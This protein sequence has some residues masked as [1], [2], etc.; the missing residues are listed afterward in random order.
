VL[1]SPSVTAST[2]RTLLTPLAALNAD[3]AAASDEESNPSHFHRAALS[4][5]SVFE[6]VASA[7]AAV[8]A[9]A[10]AVAACEV[11]GGSVHMRE[12]RGWGGGYSSACARGGT[13][14]QQRR[15]DGTL[16][17]HTLGTNPT[18]VDVDKRKIS[19]DRGCNLVCCYSCCKLSVCCSS[20]GG[21]EVLVRNIPV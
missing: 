1:S 20:L 18:T 17:H 2:T 8:A 21:L 13:R 12:D 3:T 7:A 6:A 16:L 10:A 11:G 14:H 5:A 4:N 15:L 9:A 19:T